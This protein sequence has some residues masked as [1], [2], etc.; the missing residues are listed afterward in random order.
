MAGRGYDLN[1]AAYRYGFNG[2]ENDNEVKGAGNQQDYGMRIYDPRIGKFL[3]VDPITNQY[4][5]LTPYQFASNTP[6]QA[7]DLDGLEEYHYSLTLVK[8]KPVL[9]LTTVVNEKKFLDIIPYKPDLSYV[10]DYKGETYSFGTHSGL[11]TIGRTATETVKEFVKNPD[12]GNFISNSAVEEQR[13][14]IEDAYGGVLSLAKMVVDKTLTQPEGIIYKRRDKTGNQK[15]Y[16]GQAKSEKRYKERQK[17][18]QRAN[19]DAD[20]EFEKIDKGKPGKNLDAKEQKHIDAGCGPT[21]KSNPNG[22]L[23]NK[24]NVIKK[25]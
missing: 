2:K 3:S 4:P 25:E 13:E 21:N 14:F 5:E 22:G 23:S 12:A 15:D 16:V 6:I 19:K 20:Y 10:V 11:N 1:N 24:K 8:E 18:H 9:K 17:E 7:I